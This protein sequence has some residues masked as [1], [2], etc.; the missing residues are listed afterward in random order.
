MHAL[1]MHCST[2]Q[3]AA[4]WQVAVAVF[5][6]P[7]GSQPSGLVQLDPVTGTWSWLT[8]HFGGL[9]HGIMFCNR[10]DQPRPFL[11]GLTSMTGLPG[12]LVWT[13]S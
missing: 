6:D 10:L 9:R 1:L 11:Q 5:P 12:M 8:N 4:R 3:L 2:S 13:M 7:E